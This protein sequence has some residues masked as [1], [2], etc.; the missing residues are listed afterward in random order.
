MR[1]EVRIVEVTLPFVFNGLISSGGCSKKD[2]FT[3]SGIRSS[4]PD[5]LHG[6][7]ES[8]CRRYTKFRDSSRPDTASGRH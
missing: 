1:F 3:V 2:G 6:R 7:R 4:L 8:P 5:S